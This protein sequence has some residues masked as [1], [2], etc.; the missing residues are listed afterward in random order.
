M[1]TEEDT[2]L[3]DLVAQTLE[4]NGILNKIRAELRANVFIALEEQDAAQNEKVSNKPLSQ[5]LDTK[6]GHQAFSLVRE[7]LQFF[8]LD[9]TLAVLEPESNYVGKSSPRD[10]LRSDMGLTKVDS[11]KPLLVEL[12]KGKKTAGG[13]TLSSSSSTSLSKKNS[14]KIP[15]RKNSSEEMKIKEPAAVS[16]EDLDNE[17]DLL[18]ELGV[19]PISSFNSNGTGGKK[20]PKPSWLGPEPADLTLDNTPKKPAS[21]GS[22]K[23][24]PP[25]PGLGASSLRPLNDI[26][27]GPDVNSPEWDDLM[28]IDQKI[29]QLGFKIPAKDNSTKDNSAKDNSAKDKSNGGGSKENSRRYSYDDDYFVGSASI[30]KSD[31]LSITEEI[32]GDLSIGSFAASKAD[33]MLTTDQTVSQLSGHGFDYG[34]EVDF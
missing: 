3:R 18:K 14:S 25:L 24:A 22:L 12:M 7:F 5:F 16:L 9:F 31:K 13:E 21:L 6:E 2:E 8:N 4:T 15:Q 33:E 1:S 19:S 20:N 32:E 11:R 10:D 27:G 28:K 26:T 30:E 34:E 29:S 23:D 17:D